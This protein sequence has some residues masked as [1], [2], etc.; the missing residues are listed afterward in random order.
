MLVRS[1]PITASR[2]ELT[3]PFTLLTCRPTA[4]LGDTLS[5]DPHLVMR[6][7]VAL[8]SVDVAAQIL[9]HIAKVIRSSDPEG[10]VDLIGM[11]ELQGRLKRA[12]SI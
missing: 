10:A 11:T 7:M 3:D 6:H 2:T 12:G 4:F 5:A 1:T 8:Q 9:G